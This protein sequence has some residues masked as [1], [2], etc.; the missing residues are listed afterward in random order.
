MSVYQKERTQ[1]SKV[2]RVGRSPNFA[3]HCEQHG[4]GGDQSSGSP[5]IAN[6]RRSNLESKGEG[7]TQA[8]CVTEAQD[9]VSATHA[10]RKMLI[11]FILRSEANRTLRRQPSVL[12]VRTSS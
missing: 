10:N 3:Q 1:V 11:D 8:K 9:Q 5:A 4:I 2:Q 12:D 7:G 6:V